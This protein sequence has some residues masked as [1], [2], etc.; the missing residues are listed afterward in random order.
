MSEKKCD[1]R[2]LH[3]TSDKMLLIITNG[4]RDK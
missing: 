4:E 2:L 1:K 3:K